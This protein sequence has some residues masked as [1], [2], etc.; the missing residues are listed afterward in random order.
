M[1]SFPPARPALIHYLKDLNFSFGDLFLQRP[2]SELIKEKGN[3][4][5]YSGFSV[6]TRKYND[7]PAR[8]ARR[9]K[10]GSF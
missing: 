6:K 9:E 2:R 4:S 10:W 3:S 5:G 8:E 7:I 1:K